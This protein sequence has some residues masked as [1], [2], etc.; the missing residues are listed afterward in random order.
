MIELVSRL[1][2]DMPIDVQAS[3]CT[4]REVNATALQG[5]RLI[6]YTVSK[7]SFPLSK[8]RAIVS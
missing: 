3:I 1:N 2:I 8:D 4:Y 6:Q 7:C 5:T